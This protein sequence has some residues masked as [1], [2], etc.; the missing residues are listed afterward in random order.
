MAYVTIPTRTSADTNSSADINQLNDNIVYLKAID[1]PIALSVGGT[2]ATSSTLFK[3][4]NGFTYT[5]Y[6]DDLLIKD[7]RAVQGTADTGAGQGTLDIKVGGTTTLSSPSFL[8]ASDDTYA[9]AT[10][11][12]TPANLIITSGDAITLD[13]GQGTNGDAADLCVFIYCEVN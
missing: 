6:G 11:T 2:L 3:T 5:W 13:Y 9:Q 7:I 12:G 8:S 4:T 1:T 10:L